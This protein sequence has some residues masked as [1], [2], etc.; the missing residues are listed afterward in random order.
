LSKKKKE[1]K[2]RKTNIYNFTLLA[3]A[4]EFSL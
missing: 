3:F 1:K 2:T 4:G